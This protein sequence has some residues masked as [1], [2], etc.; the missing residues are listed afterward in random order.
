M[1]TALRSSSFTS[2]EKCFRDLSQHPSPIARLLDFYSAS[3]PDVQAKINYSAAAAAA[4]AAAGTTRSLHG[5]YL[6]LHNI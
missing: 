1:D 4:A 3:A 5:V 6:C 2:D